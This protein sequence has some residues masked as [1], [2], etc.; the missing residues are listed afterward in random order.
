MHA[1]LPTTLEGW[2]RRPPTFTLIE[3][4]LV[5]DTSEG[6][7]VITKNSIGKLPME[8]AEAVIMKL[9]ET[10]EMLKKDKRHRSKRQRTA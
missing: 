7:G 10:V 6:G 8:H 3:S 2:K 9:M 1:Q 5:W 4:M